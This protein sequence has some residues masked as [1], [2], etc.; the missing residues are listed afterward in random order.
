M[1]HHTLTTI[2][3]EQH[4]LPIFPWEKTIPRSFT[5]QTLLLQIQ[6]LKTIGS[7]S[8]SNHSALQRGGRTCQ[9]MLQ[10]APCWDDCPTYWP[11]A[12]KSNT[13]LPQGHCT[14]QRDHSCTFK[15]MYSETGSF[16]FPYLIKLIVCLK[17]SIMKYNFVI[18][19]QIKL[20]LFMRRSHDIHKLFCSS[21]QS[22]S[23]G[24]NRTF[25]LDIP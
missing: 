17:T 14:T 5:G 15:S 16:F 2:F 9:S 20:Y 3:L 12:G 6:G 1:G 10:P 11:P 19:I 13:A 18:Q 7:R 22:S 24:S 25:F 21:L 4:T 23:D 8:T